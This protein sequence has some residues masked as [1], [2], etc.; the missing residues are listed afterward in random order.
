MARKQPLQQLFTARILGRCG[1]I[2]SPQLC[3]SISW[4]QN[5]Q[6]HVEHVVIWRR[7]GNDAASEL[8]SDI[9]G[10]V[11]LT[12]QAQDGRQSITRRQRGHQSVKEVAAQIGAH[13]HPKC[14]IKLA[15]ALECDSLE[16]SKDWYVWVLGCRSVS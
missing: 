9:I 13:S 12:W 6:Q 15:S 16:R 5:Q 4:L 3:H 10:W 1:L 2:C 11:Q 8:R 7:L 14:L